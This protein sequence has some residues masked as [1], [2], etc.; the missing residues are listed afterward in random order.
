MPPVDIVRVNQDQVKCRILSF[1][2]SFSRKGSKEMK[3]VL[4]GLRGRTWRCRD[5]WPMLSSLC[6]DTDFGCCFAF[7]R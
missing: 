6:S 5:R 1:H 7:L 2:S 4:K 3:L